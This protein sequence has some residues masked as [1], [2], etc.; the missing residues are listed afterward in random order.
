MD[1]KPRRQVRVVCGEKE[2]SARLKTCRRRRV[3]FFRVQFTQQAHDE[4]DHG[5]AFSLQ[6][7]G[8]WPATSM[9]D[10]ICCECELTMQERGLSGLLRE[11]MMG[12]C[13]VHAPARSRVVGLVKE[14]RSSDGQVKPRARSLRAFDNPLPSRG[15]AWNDN[16]VV[17]PK[18]EFLLKNATNRTQQ[19]MG[20]RVALSSHS[21][22]LWLSLWLSHALSFSGRILFACFPLTP[23]IIRLVIKA[24]HLR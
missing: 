11:C 22:Y 2:L 20:P 1:R 7:S 17:C 23:S 15:K 24:S 8:L 16:G 3:L 10:G 12:E 19:T 5:E 14:K 13:V 6:E 9:L 18:R 21:L 4:G